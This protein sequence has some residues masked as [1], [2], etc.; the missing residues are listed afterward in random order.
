MT[1]PA[2]E[3]AL[4]PLTDDD[5]LQ[6]R[7]A[8]LLQ[9]AFRRQWWTL[10]L[11]ADGRQLPVI[12]PMAGYPHDPTEPVSDEG[13]FSGTAAQ[14]LADRLAMMVEELGAAS[15]VFVW[16]RPGSAVSTPAD[17]AWARELADACRAEEVP[18]RAQFIAH[19]RGIR[20]FAPDDYA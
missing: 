3:A 6:R 15:V 12:M 1:I 19:S 4:I 5:A 16:E 10:Y 14:L 8:D 11:D 13:G 18:V 2:D 20:W 9:S 7:V 17:R